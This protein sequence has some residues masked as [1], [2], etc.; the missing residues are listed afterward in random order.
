MLKLHVYILKPAPVKNKNKNKQKE[1]E[2]E[3][4]L[5]LKLHTHIIYYML[6]NMYVCM[7]EF[8]H[9]LLLLL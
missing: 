6:C 8:L 2:E 3:R 1:E 7:H 9:F 5:T 4:T